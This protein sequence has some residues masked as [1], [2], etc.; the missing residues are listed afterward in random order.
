MKDFENRFWYNF[1]V[2][3]KFSSKFEKS[4]GTFERNDPNAPALDRN[5]KEFAPVK[6]S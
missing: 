3:S 6:L 1:S 2:G 5:G 4:K